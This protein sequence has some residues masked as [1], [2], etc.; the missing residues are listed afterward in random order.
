MEVEMEEFAVVLAVIGGLSLT[1][2]KVVDLIRNLVDQNDSA[3]KWVWN[4]AAFGVGVAFCLGWEKNLTADLMRLVPALA[5]DTD[6]LGGVLGQVVSGFMLGGFA[7]F[8]HEL[9]D[10]L[11]PTPVE[12]EAT[13]VDTIRAQTTQ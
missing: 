13:G 3:P 11:S 7:G 4:V 5:R 12:I 9:L 2:T 10:R 8:G 1:V 6:G